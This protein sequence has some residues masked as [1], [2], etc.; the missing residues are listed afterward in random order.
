MLWTRIGLAGCA[1][2]SLLVL[3][4]L[5]KSSGSFSA[6]NAPLTERQSKSRSLPPLPDARTADL[7][8]DSLGTVL[9]FQ[10]EELELS[11]E[12]YATLKALWIDYEK[13]RIHGEWKIQQAGTEAIALSNDVNAD[14]ETIESALMRLATALTSL[15]LQS[16]KTLRALHAVLP[17]QQL[18][19]WENL[20]KPKIKPKERKSST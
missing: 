9:A 4:A 1:I 7:L 3:S 11:D 2:V 5:N 20:V 6:V 14:L 16:I 8:L 19:K 18:K 17:P 10:R 13:G 15:Q 12:Q